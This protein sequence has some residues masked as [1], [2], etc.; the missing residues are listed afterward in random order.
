VQKFKL[1]P[2]KR[3]VLKIS[4]IVL[5]NMQEEKLKGFRTQKN[6]EGL[7]EVVFKLGED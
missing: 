5:V 4:S 3:T 1:Y 2:I 7:R 6:N